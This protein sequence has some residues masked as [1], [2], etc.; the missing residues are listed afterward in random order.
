MKKVKIICGG[1]FN[2]IHRGHEFFLRE[3]KKLGD[4]LVVM[5][6]HD[7]LNKRKIGKKAVSALQRKKAV[8]K[9]GIANKVIIGDPKDRMKIVR[10]E[11]PDV[12][13][14]GYD[15]KMPELDSVKGINIVRLGKMP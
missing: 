5:I 10:K 6:S 13:A 2:M 8:E 12:I 3:A 14:L 9:L 7:D 1:G 4:E 15:Q 11:R